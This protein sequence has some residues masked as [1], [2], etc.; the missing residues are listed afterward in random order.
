MMMSSSAYRSF[1]TARQANYIAKQFVLQA[2]PSL[3]LP[4]TPKPCSMMP[5]SAGREWQ[6]E[7][8]LFIALSKH[9]EHEHFLIR[10]IH[11]SPAEQEL[12]CVAGVFSQAEPSK[13]SQSRTIKTVHLVLEIN[14]SEW[15]EGS[16]AQLRNS[17]TT[18]AS[19]SSMYHMNPIFPSANI[20]L[21]PIEQS[22]FKTSCGSQQKAT[23]WREWAKSSVVGCKNGLL[24]IATVLV[25]FTSRD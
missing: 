4:R 7:I 18:L 9:T 6:R 16:G 17:L 2:I 25:R 21:I 12:P 5:S 20:S 13:S 19:N 15:S 24:L 10:C 3:S 23:L 8:P 11:H 1:P 22:V 14:G